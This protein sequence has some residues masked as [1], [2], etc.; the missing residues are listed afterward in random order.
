MITVFSYDRILQEHLLIEKNCLNEANVIMAESL[1]YLRAAT[2]KELRS[3]SAS[4]EIVDIIYYEVKDSIDAEMLRQ[5]RKSKNE[6]RLLLITEPTVSPLLY[7]RP[8][9]SPDALLLRPF[10]GERL[11]KT[12]HEVFLLM[13][14]RQKEG[15][16]E[17]FVLDTKSCKLSLYYQNVLAFEAN[18]KKITLRTDTE[19]YD[20]Y[21]SIENLLK[22]TPHYI[23]RCHRSFLINV[24]RIARIEFSDAL[25][26]MDDGTE[27]PLSRSYK[28]EVKCAYDEIFIH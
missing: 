17:K 10:S 20:F 23:V 15:S 22:Q 1:H 4:S 27:F 14:E 3:I 13:G 7:L 26:V 2:P 12:N 6:A 19:E 28:S 11:K 25:I 9:I 18:N 21:D 24:N 5:L 8:G 16:S